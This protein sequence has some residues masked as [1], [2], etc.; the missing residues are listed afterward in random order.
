MEISEQWGESGPPPSYECAWYQFIQVSEPQLLSEVLALGCCNVMRSN[1]H[2][3]ST[4]SAL[5]RTAAAL[6]PRGEVS[7][8]VSVVLTAGSARAATTLAAASKA[9]PSRI[10]PRLVTM[11]SMLRVTRGP[12]VAGAGGRQGL[13]DFEPEGDS[14]I[15]KR[16]LCGC[17]RSQFAVRG[18]LWVRRNATRQDKANPRSAPQPSNAAVEQWGPKMNEPRRRVG[19]RV[20][21][22]PGSWCGALPCRT[23]S[24]P[25]AL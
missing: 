9:P 15:E 17:E 3:L 14:G 22:A 25:L 11:P 16:L 8:R 19:R 24:A 5:R 10:E 21:P 12:G 2:S 23:S 7:L 4:P 20:F 13:L 6:G 1:R 18:N